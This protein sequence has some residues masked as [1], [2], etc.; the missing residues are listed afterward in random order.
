MIDRNTDRIVIFCYPV[1]AGGKFLIN[2]LGL[3]DDCVL[4]HRDLVGYSYQDK[5]T[6]IK[7][8][9]ELSEQSRVWDDLGL[10]CTQLFGVGVNQYMSRYPSELEQFFDPVI[11]ELSHGSRYFF[12]VAH[13]TLWTEAYLRFWPNARL[14]F[15]KNCQ[16]FLRHRIKKSTNMPVDPARV[17]QWNAVRGQ[18]WPEHP[19]CNLDEFLT[20]SPSVQQELLKDFYGLVSACVAPESL[21]NSWQDQAYAQEVDRLHALYGSR[22]SL[23][24]N[25]DRGYENSQQFLEQIRAV[26]D[27]LDL[28]NTVDSRDLT[29]YFDT[30]KRTIARTQIT[31]LAGELKN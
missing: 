6:Y 22:R 21:P 24:W 11:H 19:P 1:G 14:V 16:G 3:H 20:F 25:C 28:S 7:T 5:L 12:L 26:F 8:Q 2:S 18:D 15:F 31:Q 10:G 29:W 17:Q 13:N 30:W 4:Q 9:L 23:I 27:W